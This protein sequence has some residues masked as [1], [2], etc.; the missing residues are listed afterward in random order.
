[1]SDG[2]RWSV[3]TV[4]YNSAPDLE[5]SYTQPAPAGVEW[6]VVD[7]ASRDDSADVAQQLG[8]RVIRMPENIG[9]GR[10]NNEGFRAARGEFVVFANPDLRVEFDSLAILEN[11]LE[12]RGGLVAPQ[13]VN[14][15]GSP[16]PNGRRSPSLTNKVLSRLGV[17][18][19]RDTYYILAESDE[20]RYVAW[21]IG[22]VVAARAD[23]FRQLGAEGPWD[24][25]YFVYYE[26]SDLGLR[27]WEAGFAVRIVGA[28]RWT[29]LWARDTARAFRLQPWLL[30]W[31][32]MR[33]FYSRWPLF[34]AGSGGRRWRRLRREFWGRVVEREEKAEG[35][36][37]Q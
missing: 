24:P 4:S 35:A 9:F 15:D 1:M 23:T 11:A 21:A 30:E 34:L 17:R 14:P 36:R 10:A 33:L 18:P 20:E 2:I 12:R 8:A 5:Q 3:V 37:T 13:L 29:H 27:A 22:A 25:R 28:V 31:S 7:N 26:D 32:G 6:I 19:V 16:Q